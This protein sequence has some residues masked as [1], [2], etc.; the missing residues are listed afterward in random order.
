[1][2]GTRRRQYVD[3]VEEGNAA[4]DRPGRNPEGD[5]AIWAHLFVGTPR[6]ID[7]LLRAL[8]LDLH[9]SSPP[10]HTRLYMKQVLAAVFGRGSFVRGSSCVE[11]PPQTGHPLED[12]LCGAMRPGGSPPAPS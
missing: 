8:L 6:N 4:D 2:Q 7:I 3:I 11:G 1:M 12:L 10:S 5:G 9:P